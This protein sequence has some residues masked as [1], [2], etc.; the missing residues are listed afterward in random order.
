M[1]ELPFH[2]ME[3][4]GNDF[5]VVYAAALPRPLTPADAIRLCDRHFGVGADG[6]LVVGVGGFVFLVSEG[7]FGGASSLSPASVDSAVASKPSA[8]R[9]SVKSVQRERLL[10]SV[11]YNGGSAPTASDRK[12]ATASR[13][14]LKE[15]SRAKRAEGEAPPQEAM[16][17]LRDLGYAAPDAEQADADNPTSAPNSTL[18]R[19]ACSCK[20]FRIARS[21]RS[22]SMRIPL[23]TR[24]NVAQCEGLAKR[25]AHTSRV[26]HDIMQE[27]LPLR[28]F[29]A[30]W[31]T[32]RD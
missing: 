29:H 22:S 7:Y 4:C 28:G 30:H 9:R 24:M 32:K 14:G 16:E 12:P 10:N 13:P 8:S 23:H 17:R 21:I 1:G 18:V 27:N 11:G 25:F 6:V 2:K 26:F 15:G 3:A 5:V 20:A 31:R 19:R